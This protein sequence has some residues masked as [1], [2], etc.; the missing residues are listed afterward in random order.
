MKGDM[1]FE[2]QEIGCS[3]CHCTFAVSGI[4]NLSVQQCVYFKKG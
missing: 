4:L 2:D 3:S 1:H